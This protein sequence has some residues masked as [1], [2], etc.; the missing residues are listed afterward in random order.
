MKAIIFEEFG[1]YDKLK[2]ID[3]PMPEPKQGQ[4]LIKVNVAAVNPVDNTLRLGEIKSRVSFPKILGNEAAGIVIKGNDEFPDG[5]RVIISCYD[6]QGGVRGI[7]SEG[8]WQEYLALYPDEL[9]KIPDSVSDETAAAFPVAYFSAWACL[10]KAGFTPGQSVL[11]F[12]AGGAV[13][14]AGVQL[15]TALGASLVITTAGS[16]E[17]AAQ[18]SKAGIR[19]VI[20]LSQSSL[21][22][23]VMLITQNKGVNTVIDMVGGNLTGQALSAL[24][25]DGVLV[26]IG[27]SAGVQFT[28]KITDFVWKRIQMRGQSLSA[29]T[30]RN[31]HRQALD[32]ML[33]LLA[34]GKLQPPVAKVFTADQ[35]G[36]A[37]RYMIEDRP[38]GKVLFTFQQAAPHLR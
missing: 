19:N 33:P 27:Y 22:D 8:A 2:I 7:T 36:E 18:A 10:D 4:L 24:A 14:N 29:Y 1:G 20:D 3:R 16:T 37:H 6:A 17:K 21:I 34:E 38:Y 30:D 13:G 9:I 23:A 35:I 15:A 26:T 5:T 12:A 11:S 32:T 25:Q 28:A 31:K